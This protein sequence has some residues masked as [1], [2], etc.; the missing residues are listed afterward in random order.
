[1]HHW[2]YAN[3]LCVTHHLNMPDFSCGGLLK[4]GGSRQRK[5]GI[6]NAEEGYTFSGLLFSVKSKYD[7]V[8][9]EKRNVI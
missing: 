4:M 2:V 9:H 8:K 7:T 3:N 5:S 6:E 1:M